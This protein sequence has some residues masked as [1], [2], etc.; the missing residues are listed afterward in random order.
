MFDF[1]DTTTLIIYI[2]SLSTLGFH[3]GMCASDSYLHGR[4]WIRDLFSIVVFAYFLT[5]AYAELS[6]II[7]KKCNN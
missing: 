3:I 1:S 7:N 5:Y 4:K 6:E 2:F